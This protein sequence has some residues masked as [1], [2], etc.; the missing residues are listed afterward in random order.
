MW[1]LKII[2]EN[3]MFRVNILMCMLSCIKAGMDA[4]ILCCG[5]TLLRP[6]ISLRFRLLFE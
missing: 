4:M 2:L 5:D 1:I 6:D 3:M